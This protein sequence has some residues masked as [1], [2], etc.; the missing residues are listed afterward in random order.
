MVRIAKGLCLT[1]HYRTRKAIV[2]VDTLSKKSFGNL[3]SLITTQRHVLE[4]MRRWNLEVR[5][6]KSRV[7]LANLRIKPMLIDRIKLA[8][9]SEPY[10]QM[11]RVRLKCVCKLSHSRGW[12]LVVW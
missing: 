3:G 10:L 8:P 5:F 2:V 9:S 12:F 7:Q 4:D 1:I 6:P 11:I